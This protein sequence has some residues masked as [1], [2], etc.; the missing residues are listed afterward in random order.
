MSDYEIETVDVV[1][2]VAGD[3]GPA[4]VV[5][6]VGRPNVGKSTLVNRILGRRE[7]VVEDV[8]GVTRDRVAYDAAW[9]GRRFTV[10]DTGGWLPD[11]SG[12]AAAIAEQARLAVDLADVV[13]F[14]V[15]A[16]VGATDVDEAVVEIL[17]RAGKPVVLVA[18]KVDD[19][20]AESDAALLW[21]LGIGEPHPVSALHGRGSGDLLDAV[22]EALPA[23][24]PPET[25]GEAGGPRRIALLG[26]PNVG[27]SSLLNKLAGENRAVVDSVAGTTRDPVDELIELGGRTW[28]F[29][30]TA[31]I[32][33]RHRENQGADFYATLRTQSALERAEV[34]VVLVDADQPLAEQ[35]LRIILMVI[36]SG[37]SLV[38]AYN[39]WD[40]L[41]E[42]RR[43][44]LEREIDR[45]LHNARWAPRVNISAKTGRHVEK[46]VP[47]IETALAG[48]ETRVPT[49]KLNQ[50]FAD[51]VN[52]HP[53]P[54]RGGKQPRV[55]FATQ[56][57][58]RPPRF[59]LFTSGFLEEGYRRFIERRLREEFGFAGTPLDITMKIREKRGKNRR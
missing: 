26:R 48:W 18:N 57:G 44:Y 17:R 2:D 33:R 40:L 1:E 11:S 31:G 3:A 47:G 38:L 52:S 21:S 23:E 58:V 50:F 41:D 28:R 13:M 27:K 20:G 49:S 30:D 42:E 37:R 46:L 35:D 29:I 9:S 15:D 19:A 22:L 14:V 12:L 34:A 7:A 32:R 24:P 16:T 51:L 45:Q 59:V 5:A 55:L 53:H 36:E 8:P 10:V 4:P 43:H 39:K 6:V 54:V 56:A 25:F